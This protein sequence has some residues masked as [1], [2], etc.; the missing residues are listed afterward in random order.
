MPS[1]LSGWGPCDTYAE[2]PPQQ[3]P[4]ARTLSP[5]P[6]MEL[7]L[8]GVPKPSHPVTMSE[9][10]SWLKEILC[11]M[12]MLRLCTMEEIELLTKGAVECTF[13]PNEDVVREGSMGDDMYVIKRGFAR[14]G[15]RSTRTN[16]GATLARGL[17]L[18][19]RDMRELQPSPRIHHSK[20]SRCRPKPSRKRC[21]C[22]IGRRT[23]ST[24]PL[25]HTT[26]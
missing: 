2:E 5:G 16:A 17:L 15:S 10:Q 3:K 12:P 9:S 13:Q 4:P 8:P 14:E 19:L 18:A 23:E 20:C 11:S 22:M 25:W 26:R 24:S 6:V 7:G 1:L 21:P